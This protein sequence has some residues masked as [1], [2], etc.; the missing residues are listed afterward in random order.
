[1]ENTND[2][3]GNAIEIGATYGY[4]QTSNGYSQVIVGTAVKFTPKGYVT[5]KPISR[6]GAIYNSVPEEKELGT[7]GSVKP[8]HLFPVNL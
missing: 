6:K 7:P 2:A 5:I 4:S 3:L 8:I 1:M